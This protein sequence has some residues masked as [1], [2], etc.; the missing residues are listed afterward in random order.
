MGSGRH[1]RNRTKSSLSRL[2]KTIERHMF[3][4]MQTPL[5]VKTLVEV[6]LWLWSRAD[7]RQCRCKAEGALRVGR[8]PKGR[9]CVLGRFHAPRDHWRPFEAQLAVAGVSN[10]TRAS[11]DGRPSRFKTSCTACSPFSE[12]Q[13]SPRNFLKPGTVVR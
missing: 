3:S 2:P 6:E 7:R 8:R 9:L 1:R 5:A 13:C 12:S 10:C 4:N 11:P